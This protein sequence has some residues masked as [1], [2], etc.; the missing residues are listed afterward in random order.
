[1]AINFVSMPSEIIAFVLA[2]LISFSILKRDPKY[3]G[4]QFFAS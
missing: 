3:R 1:M 2:M 4:N